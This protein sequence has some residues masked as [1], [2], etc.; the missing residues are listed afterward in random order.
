ME[1]ASLALLTGPYELTR[2]KTL[3]A[4]AERASVR[5]NRDYVSREAIL[6]VASSIAER[7]R[8]TDSLAT[9]FVIFFLDTLRAPILERSSLSKLSTVL[10]HDGQYRASFGTDD[11]HLEQYVR[12][13]FITLPPN[14]YTAPE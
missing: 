12:L 9:S 4:P 2:Q 1:K 10:P 8:A 5:K 14:Q 11:P 3:A 13:T 7:S 6:L